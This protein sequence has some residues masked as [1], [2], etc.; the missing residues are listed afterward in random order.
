MVHATVTRHTFDRDSL[1]FVCNYKT[2]I[3]G[4][5]MHIILLVSVLFMLD[6]V[7]YT[8]DMFCHEM[9]LIDLH[10]SKELDIR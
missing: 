3:P 8:G 2:E 1:I 7:G 9:T 6:L 4:L 5:K 10:C